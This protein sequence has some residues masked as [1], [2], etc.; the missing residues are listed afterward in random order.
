MIHRTLLLGP[1]LA[2]RRADLVLLDLNTIP[3]TP[4]NNALHQLVFGST[5]LA[6]DSA[7]A[8]IRWMASAST[9]ND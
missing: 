1:V 3:F 4:L 8:L 6:V 9:V 7:L 5:T 2:G